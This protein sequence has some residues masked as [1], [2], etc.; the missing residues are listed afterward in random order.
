MP[1]DIHVNFKKLNIDCHVIHIL[2]IFEIFSQAISKGFQN[3]S[4]DFEIV[5]EMYHCIK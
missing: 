1:K 5:T 3:I 2:F 4:P